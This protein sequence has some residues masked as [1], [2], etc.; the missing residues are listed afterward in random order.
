MDILNNTVLNS[1]KL[2]QAHSLLKVIDAY[3]AQGDSRVSVKSPNQKKV[4]NGKNPQEVKAKP[5]G[6]DQEKIASEILKLTKELNAVKRELKES[7]HKYKLRD[8]E[9]K[10]LKK[11]LETKS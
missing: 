9:I 2:S 8:K 5:S 4:I 3:E 11:C 7:Q 10:D 6:Q 1:S